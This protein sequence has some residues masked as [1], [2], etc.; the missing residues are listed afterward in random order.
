MQRKAR[1]LHKL[2][3]LRS[4]DMVDLQ[5]RQKADDKCFNTTWQGSNPAHVCCYFLRNICNGCILSV[6]FVEQL[7]T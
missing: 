6:T 5:I 2:Q 1:D 7:R 4:S 3:I